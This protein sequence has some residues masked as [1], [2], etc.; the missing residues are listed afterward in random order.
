M[1]KNTS[2]CVLFFFM[3][4]P[5]VAQQKITTVGIQIK[6]IFPNSFFST[7]AKTAYQDGVKFDLM[8][9]G[10][11]SA[12]MIVR[13][14][15]SDLLAIESGINYT[16]RTFQLQIS[17][18]KLNEE[19]RFRIIGYEI[20]INLLVYI[21]LSEK[22]FMNASMGSCFD[23]F[24][25][26]VQSHDYYFSQRSYRKSLFQPAVTGNLG[27][28]YRTST[29]GYIY[30]GATY[31]RPFSYIYTSKINYQGNKNPVDVNL[32]GN[33]LTIDLRYFFY[34]DP[35]KKTKPRNDEIE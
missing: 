2:L 24:A 5:L 19:S 31:H 14:G 20:P 15:F 35:K 28:E 1:K 11:F 18:R 16:K 8:L 7:V 21:R 13:H 12:G 32:E 3:S 10:G 22:I 25:S 34:E 23:M 29:S 30:L 17:D 26:D 27:W 6:P 9:G 33:Y 4:L